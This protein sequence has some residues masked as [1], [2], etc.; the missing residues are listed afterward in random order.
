MS[1]ADLRSALETLGD[2]QTVDLLAGETTVAMNT[3]ACV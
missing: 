3:F 1:M 2:E